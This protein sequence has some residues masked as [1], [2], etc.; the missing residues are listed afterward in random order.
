ML[1]SADVLAWFRTMQFRNLFLDATS[2]NALI[3]LMK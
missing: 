3:S 2:E 1:Q